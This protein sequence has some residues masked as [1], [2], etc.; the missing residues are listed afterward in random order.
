MIRLSVYIDGTETRLRIAIV[1]DLQVM[2]VLWCLADARESQSIM[3][4]RCLMMVLET[5]IRWQAFALA[6]RLYVS[7]FW[8]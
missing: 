3:S 6:A 5:E 7:V 8:L 1:L 4:K 2:T